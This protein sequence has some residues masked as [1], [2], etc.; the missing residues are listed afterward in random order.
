M[1]NND[2][3]M[4]VYPDPDGT[5]NSDAFAPS[6]TNLDAASLASGAVA[7]GVAVAGSG[8]ATSGIGFLF[9]TAPHAAQASGG[10]L[11]FGSASAGYVAAFIFFASL[12]VVLGTINLVMGL[13]MKKRLEGFSRSVYKLCETSGLVKKK[14]A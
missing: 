13:R 14:A 8:T 3:P 7:V 11:F 5:T 9:Q 4:H 10:F 12:S 6:N 1:P 2:P